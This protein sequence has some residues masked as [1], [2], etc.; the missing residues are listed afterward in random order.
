MGQHSL[1]TLWQHLTSLGSQSLG[2]ILLLQAKIT[3]IGRGINLTA[4]S[5]EKGNEHT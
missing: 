1:G 2:V 4:R 5:Q 3:W